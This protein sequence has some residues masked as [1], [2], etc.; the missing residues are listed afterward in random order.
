[1]PLQ[2][3][4]KSYGANT[5]KGC[6]YTASGELQCGIVGNDGSS[7]IMKN[8]NVAPYP[9]CSTGCTMCAKPKPAPAQK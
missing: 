8:A 4:K 7:I 3:V 1:M 5:N 2:D 6:M 9:D